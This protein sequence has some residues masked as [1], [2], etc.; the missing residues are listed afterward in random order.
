MKLSASVHQYQVIWT[1]L[2][3]ARFN[4]WCSLIKTGQ[5][6][7]WAISCAPV[8]DCYGKMGE[9]QSRKKKIN[10]RSMIFYLHSGNPN[11]LNKFNI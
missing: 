10:P 1:V 8:T 7:Y 2:I 9:S 5:D 11:W 3:C 4:N 6:V